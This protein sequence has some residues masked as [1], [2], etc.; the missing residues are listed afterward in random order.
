MAL[1]FDIRV[2]LSFRLPFQKLDVNSLSENSTFLSFLMRHFRIF[3][4]VSIAAIFP[5]PMKEFCIFEAVKIGDH[6]A[7]IALALMLV[8]R[9]CKTAKITD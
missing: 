8:T 3:F 4:F 7:Q 1:E 6:L 5:F 9:E 2:L